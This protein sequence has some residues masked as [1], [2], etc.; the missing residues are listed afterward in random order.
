MVARE[1]QI[2]HIEQIYMTNPLSVA[3]ELFHYAFWQPTLSV[4]QQGF[5]LEAGNW[6]M[7]PHLLTIW[8]PVAFGVSLVLLL[9]GNYLFRKFEGNFAQEL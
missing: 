6:H 3:V 4:E 8:V 5:L 2:P 1:V 9:L 7:F